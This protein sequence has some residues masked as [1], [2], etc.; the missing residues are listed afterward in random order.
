LFQ[1][2]AASLAGEIRDQAA[3]GATLYADRRFW[4]QLAPVRFLAGTAP[5]LYWYEAADG[6]QPAVP[7]RHTVVIAW[8]F[9]PVAPL[10]QSL[11]PG[12]VV[13]ATPGPLYRGDLEPAPYPL[14]AV[15]DLRPLAG[16]PPAPLARFEGGL[17]LLA[18][19]VAPAPGGGRVDLLWEAERAPGRDVQVFAQALEGE[20]LLSQADGPLGSA[21]YPSSWWRAGERVAETRVFT[22]P[23][24]A[25]WPGTILHIG[26]YDLASG[27][28]LPRVDQPG[29]MY[30][31]VASDG[32]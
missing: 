31:T 6:L 14:Y 13:H 17:A 23:A 28:R 4:D 8:P 19:V 27:A 1:A 15:Y 16:E 9:E 18:C 22:L 21:L 30:E 20:A 3:A 26:L 24:G 12:P 11:A 5:N 32:R 10:L 29:D 7:L 2:A 25:D